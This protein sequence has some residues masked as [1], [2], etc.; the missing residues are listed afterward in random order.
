MSAERKLS[1][2]QK[3]QLTV[4]EAKAQNS[5]LGQLNEMDQEISGVEK[6]IKTAS[7]STSLRVKEN[8]GTEL[9]DMKV[10]RL[11]MLLKDKE[12]QGRYLSRQKPQITNMFEQ[13]KALQP[14]KEGKKQLNA[15]V[16]KAIISGFL[17]G[18]TL[19]DSRNPDVGNLRVPQ[20]ESRPTT[21]L[22]IKLQRAIVE[23]EVASISKAVRFTGEARNPYG[24]QELV[25]KAADFGW[26][27]TPLPK[28]KSGNVDFEK[29]EAPKVGNP[30]LQASYYGLVKLI[31]KKGAELI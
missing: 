5:T 2:L 31:R 17:E 23:F 15:L 24:L 28:T 22:L 10:D 8:L 20:M 7:K 19:V 14:G 21:E 6:I 11:V 26:I 3:A 29:L 4:E 13:V 18:S 30:R 16:E 27:N 1:L 25:I 9:E 12:I